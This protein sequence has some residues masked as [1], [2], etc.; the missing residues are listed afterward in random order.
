MSS[1]ECPATEKVCKD[2]SKK[3]PLANFYKTKRANGAVRYLA[4]CKPCFGVRSAASYQKRREANLKRAKKYRKENEPGIKAYL[5][6][7]YKENRE[8]VIARSKAYR[9]RPDRVM[10]DKERQERRYRERRDEIRDKQNARNATPEGRRK[11]KARYLK[12]YSANKAYYVAKG[13]LRRVKRVTATPPWV[14]SVD[15][16]PYYEMA[17]DLTK[18]TGVKHVVDHIVPLTHE[19]VCGLHV[20]WNLQVIPELDNLRKHNRLMR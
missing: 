3:L 12:H 16:L 4:V 19:A 14:L 15:T 20:P 18:R 5:R 6:K 1:Q 11:Q 7:W 17:R 8:A 2:C 13:G 10:A 9:K